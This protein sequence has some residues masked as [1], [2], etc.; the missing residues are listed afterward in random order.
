M[1]IKYI[2]S[3]F[4]IH[5]EHDETEM[6]KAVYDRIDEIDDVMTKAL[7]AISKK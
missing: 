5:D 4:A 2:M 1:Q 7:S 6:I 3:A